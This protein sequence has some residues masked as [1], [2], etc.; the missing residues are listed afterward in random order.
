MENKISFKANF[1][2]NAKILK[3]HSADTTFK[4]KK[5]SFVE[6]TPEHTPDM[7]AVRAVNRMWGDRTTLAND[8]VDEMRD[9]TDFFEQGG[10]RFFAITEQRGSFEK[11]KPSK[12]LGLAETIQGNSKH[13]K[14]KAIQ[15]HPEHQSGQEGAKFKHIGTSII[16][17]LKKIFPS[18]KNFYGQSPKESEGFCSANGF[19]KLDEDGNMELFQ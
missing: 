1:I 12:I 3:L 19:V 8:I 13:I 4:P 5:V 16:D 18:G 10:K 6:L 14:I 11:L 2:S 15:V 9:S 17:S 7:E